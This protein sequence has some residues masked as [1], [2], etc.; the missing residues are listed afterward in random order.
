MS[1]PPN[2]SRGAI[3]Y[4]S[5]TPLLFSL[6]HKLCSVF[7]VLSFDLMSLLCNHPKYAD[8]CLPFK[9]SNFASKKQC[10]I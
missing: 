3:G 4:D 10:S 9:L 2:M 5:L 7:F 1:L 6:K 8:L